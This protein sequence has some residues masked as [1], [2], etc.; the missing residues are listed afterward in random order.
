MFL[1]IVRDVES[2]VWEPD[3]ERA[4]IQERWLA[5]GRTAAAEARR[6][7]TPEKIEAWRA[8]RDRLQKSN[9]Q[10]SNSRAAQLIAPGESASERTIRR[11]LD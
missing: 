11:H 8:E 1:Q 5:S 7:A 3:R 6:I 4:A 10:I 2:E 9:P